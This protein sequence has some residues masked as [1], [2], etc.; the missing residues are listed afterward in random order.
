MAAPCSPA[1]PHTRTGQRR[2]PGCVRSCGPCLSPLECVSGP[3]GPERPSPMGD[4]GHGGR[5]RQPYTGGLPRDV[6]RYLARLAI[7]LVL[8]VPPVVTLRA[9]RPDGDLPVFRV[10][11]A[12]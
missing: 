2:A 4:H 11:V 8:A 5:S 1:E 10:G 7:A 9:Q 3:G 12:L 6:M